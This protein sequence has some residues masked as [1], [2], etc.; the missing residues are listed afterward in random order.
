[1]IDSLANAN[2]L[3]YMKTITV[4]VSDPIYRD[5]TVYAKQVG[6]SASELIRR[7]MEDYHQR[8]I[9]RKTTLR[10]RRPASVGGLLQPIGR[11]ED[12]LPADELLGRLLEEGRKL[13][14]APQM[15]AEF[16]HVVTDSKRLKEPLS[17]E[18]ALAR[19]EYWWQAREVVRIYPEGDAVS[20]WIEWLRD[21]RLGRKRLLDTMLAASACAQGISTIV[22]NN[23]KDFQIF[24]RFKILTYNEQGNQ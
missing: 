10:N 18:E 6:N 23:A 12:L 13:A 2:I 20:T 7:A 22:T 11:E 16:V 4:N 19:A 14:V 15:L 24:G 5:F 3:E 8:F 21:H 17:M 1:M 9:L